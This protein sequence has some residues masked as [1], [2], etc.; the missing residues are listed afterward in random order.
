MGPTL[1]AHKDMYISITGGDL[2][3]CIEEQSVPM[4]RVFLW[5]KQTILHFS[6]ARQG[7]RAYLAIAGGCDVP[8]VMGSQS[9]YIPAGIRGISRRALQAGIVSRCG[10][11]GC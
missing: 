1:L 3:P 6:G 9:T 10:E 2:D 11:S 5:K 8:L 7:L 4:W